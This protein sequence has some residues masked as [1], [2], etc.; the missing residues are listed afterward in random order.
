MRGLLIGMFYAMN[1]V[2]DLLAGLVLLTVSLSFKSNPFTLRGGLFSSRFSTKGSTM[3]KPT[4]N[5]NHLIVLGMSCGSWYYATTVVLGLLGVVIFFLGAIWYKK[6]QRGGHRTL[7]NHQ[8]IIE[9]YYEA[10][11]EQQY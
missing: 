9:S 1:G 7:I 2:F 11:S 8:T 6:R 10:S 5:Y 3:H 4:D